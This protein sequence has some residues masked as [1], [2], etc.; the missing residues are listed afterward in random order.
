MA[1]AGGDMLVP[2]VHHAGMPP[3]CSALVR[4][5]CRAIESPMARRAFCLVLS[6]RGERADDFNLDSKV[7]KKVEL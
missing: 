4:F 2:S 7:K 1:G 5:W 3:P 6:V